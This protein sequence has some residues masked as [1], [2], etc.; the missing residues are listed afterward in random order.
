M[1]KHEYLEQYQYRGEIDEEKRDKEMIKKHIR[2]SE[3]LV[4]WIQALADKN[5]RS[6]SSTIRLMLLAY[7][8]GQNLEEQEKSKGQPLTRCQ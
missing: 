5:N 7:L 3:E 8:E 6:F 2:L 1:N 4:C